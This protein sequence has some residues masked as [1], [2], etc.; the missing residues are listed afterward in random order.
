VEAT[1]RLLSVGGVASL[2]GELAVSLYDGGLLDEVV[3]TG[4]GEEASAFLMRV[5]HRR[6]RQ[7]SLRLRATGK[8]PC[9]IQRLCVHTTKERKNI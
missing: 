9:R 2:G 3:L 4:E 8:S 5:A 1:K 6:F 7:L